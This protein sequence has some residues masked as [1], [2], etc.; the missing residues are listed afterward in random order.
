MLANLCTES[1]LGDAC[2]GAAA[3][4]SNRLQGSHPTFAKLYRSTLSRSSGLNDRL[5]AS[6]GVAEGEQREAEAAAVR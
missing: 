6:P 2:P 5:A 4:D 3:F 1:K